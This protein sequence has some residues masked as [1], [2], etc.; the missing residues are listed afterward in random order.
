M[1]SNT[2]HPPGPL[3]PPVNDKNP[4]S[5]SPP[6]ALT[7][8]FPPHQLVPDSYTHPDRFP[9]S[10]Y[11]RSKHPDI[12]QA[13]AD[14]VSGAFK[15]PLTDVNPPIN[16]VAVAIKATEEYL[17]THTPMT[18]RQCS[19]PPLPLSPPYVTPVERPG[20]SRYDPEHGGWIARTGNGKGKGPAKRVAFNLETEILGD[21]EKY[22]KLEK[23]KTKEEEKR[24]KRRAELKGSISEPIGLI[25]EARKRREEKKAGRAE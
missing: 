19:T 23:K 4:K 14:S 9:Y 24:E 21:F 15:A 16:P 22:G 12:W 5:R 8:M 6:P 11:L 7:P 3:N 2:N 1:A 13:N 10:A 17:R 18:T 20:N 25:T